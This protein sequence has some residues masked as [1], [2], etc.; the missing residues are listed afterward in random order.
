MSCLILCIVVMPTNHGKANKTLRSLKLVTK[1]MHDKY[2]LYFSCNPGDSSL[3]VNVILFHVIS[4]CV[5]RCLARF[6]KIFIH[7]KHAQRASW[8]APSDN[9]T[10]SLSCRGWHAE[11]HCCRLWGQL[12]SCRRSFRVDARL[13]RYRAGSGSST[14]RPYVSS[15]GLVCSFC[16][17]W[18]VQ[19]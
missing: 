7:S 3:M 18:T 13:S 16:I 14:W 2:H 19:L 8:H 6:N 17:T 10:L 1:I 15:P 5:F 9:P 12:A 11:R 4:Y